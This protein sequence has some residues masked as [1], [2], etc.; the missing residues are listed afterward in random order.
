MS[1]SGNVKIPGR[2]KLLLFGNGLHNK[3]TFSQA[4]KMAL[5]L[6]SY[7]LTTAAGDYTSLID[8]LE[9]LGAKRVSFC[10][11]IA[12]NDATTEQVFDFVRIVGRLDPQ[13]CLIVVS[14]SEWVAANPEFPISEV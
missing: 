10:Q 5:Y 6:I 13:D 8:A 12:R 4:A 1:E 3:K 2:M 9:K 11:W 14:V 7:D